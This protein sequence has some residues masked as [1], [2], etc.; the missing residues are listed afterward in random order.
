MS[1][2]VHYGSFNPAIA[3]ERLFLDREEALSYLG[4]AGQELDETFCNRFLE[5]VQACEQSTQPKFAWAV[6]EVD[7]AASVWIGDKPCVRLKHCALELPGKDIAAHL[8]GAQQVALMACT[9]GPQNEQD[10]RR[11]KAVSVT[12]GLVYD[13]CSSALV[14]ACANAAEQPIAEYAAKR[15]LYLKWRYSPG[16]GDL[17]LSIQPAFLN[18]LDATRRL[19][20][21]TTNTCLMVPTKSI[22]ALVGLFAEP[23]ETT[24][25]EKSCDNCQVKDVCALRKSGRT[26]RG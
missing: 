15:G 21:R 22:T 26:C 18:A 13:A 9:L 7:D 2:A 10:I 4:Y 3:D 1:G 24:R 6:F 16:Y 14:E 23:Q 11:Y 20:I 25:L 19:G 5:L 8:R 17:P 12:D